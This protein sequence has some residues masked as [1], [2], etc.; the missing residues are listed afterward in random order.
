MNGRPG[1]FQVF[2]LANLMFQNE[3]HGLI[4]NVDIP[5]I[6]QKVIQDIFNVK[7][8]KRDSVKTV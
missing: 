3:G 6:E 7:N 8:R 5:E 1:V 2:S 4:G